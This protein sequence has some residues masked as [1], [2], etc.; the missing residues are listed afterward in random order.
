MLV[1]LL[2]EQVSAHWEEISY[3]I[4]SSLP[5]IA[6]ENGKM[7]NILSAILLG[8]ILCWVSIRDQRINAVVT[9]RILDDDITELKS[10]LVYTIFAME[11]SGDIDWVEGFETL[12][13]YAKSKGCSRIVGYSEFDSILTRM[14]RLGADT[15]YRF[16]SFNI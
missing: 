16:V 3:S 2:P 7:S 8:K 1:S 9:T 14:E 12:R 5:P 4:E 11:G 13:K 10:L 6:N 15:R